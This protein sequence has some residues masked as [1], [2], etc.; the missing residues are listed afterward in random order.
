M[1][2]IFGLILSML[3]LAQFSFGQLEL[4]ATISSEDHYSREGKKYSA[5]V[6]ATY[7]LRPFKLYN[8]VD[9]PYLI[10]QARSNKTVGAGFGARFDLDEV[11]VNFD[12]TFLL[13][14]K[15]ECFLKKNTVISQY[16]FY[17]DFYKLDPIYFKIGIRN[18][19]NSWDYSQLFFKIGY[20]I[21]SLKK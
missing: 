15:Q 16:A 20:R 1:K 7:K 17:L 8:V 21:G 18:Y 10:F 12:L 13:T 5:D 6:T 14:W 19:L 11:T 4:E 2:R 3:F 9:A